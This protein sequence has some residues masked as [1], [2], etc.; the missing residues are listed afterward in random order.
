MLSADTR[1]E[2]T[3]VAVRASAGKGKV[4]VF[5]DT[6]GFTNSI[7]TYGCTGWDESGPEVIYELNIPPGT[8]AD[9]IASLSGVSADLDVYLLD[10]DGCSDGE[11]LT[12]ST[13]TNFAASAS[14]VGPGRYLVAVD[15]YQGAASPYRLALQCST[16][17]GSCTSNQTTLCLNS[18]RFK[19]TAH[20]RTAAGE[21]GFGRAV[22][23]TGDT[24]YFWFFDESNVEV[25]V[26]VLRACP[27]N[28][29]YWVFA[30]GLTNVEVVLTVEDVITH[31]TQTYTNQLGDS[32]V[33]IQDTA[34]FDSCG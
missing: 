11:C 29:K 15:G 24:G 7:D 21:S 9:V 33:A 30:A 34:A 22:S 5:G 19:V 6:S 3:D 16:T 10:A 12:G 8:I 4:I 25:V 31:E 18:S 1:R 32:F 14:N 27:V 2:L 26:K 17:T 20:Y 28:G 23:M 13:V